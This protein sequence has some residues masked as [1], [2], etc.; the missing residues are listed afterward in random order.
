MI[1]RPGKTNI[2]DCLSRLNSVDQRNHR[3]EEVDFVKVIAQESTPVAMTAREVERESESDPELCSVRHCIQTGDWSQCKLPHYAY[4]NN[5]LCV[6][7]KLVTRG[8]R[9]VIPQSLGGEMLRLAHE[10]EKSV[11]NQGLAAQNG[12]RRRQSLQK[13]PWMSSRWGVSSPEAMQR[14]EPPSGPWQDVAI[15]ILG[16]FPSGELTCSGGLL[17]PFL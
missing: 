9:M 10:D 14:A 16:P 15:N 13:L 2:A 6:F 7:G 5:E 3:G 17:Q 11:E 4:V 8:T 12:P 1:Y